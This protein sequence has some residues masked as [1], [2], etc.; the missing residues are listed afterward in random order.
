MFTKTIKTAR[1]TNLPKISKRP[2][3]TGT[4]LESEGP[5]TT[6]P[7]TTSKKIRERNNKIYRTSWTNIMIIKNR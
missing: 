4:K 3:I 5:E 2:R 7:R 1:E 6:T